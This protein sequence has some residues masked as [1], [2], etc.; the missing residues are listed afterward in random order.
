MTLAP[1]LRTWPD[2]TEVIIDDSTDQANGMATGFPYPSIRLNVA[3]PTPGD[4]ISETGLWRHELIMHEYTHILNFEPAH[5]I[6]RTVRSLFGSLGR[7]NMLLP[8]WYSEGLAVDLETRFSENAGRLRS[9]IFTAI[10]RSMIQE[11]RLEKED[12]ARINESSIPDWPNGHRPYLMGSLIWN[13]LNNDSVKNAGDLNDRYGSRV[14]FFI[15]EPIQDLK[16]LSWNELLNSVY[17]STEERAVYQLE[18]ICQGGCEEG[19]KIGEPGLFSKS[20]VL[21]ASKNWLAWIGKEHNRD[22]TLMVLPR[23]EN[24]FAGVVPIRLTDGKYTN[25]IAWAGLN[26]LYD[27]AATHMRYSERNDLFLFERESKRSVQ[28]TFGLRAREAD[29]LQFAADKYQKPRFLV[30]FITLEPGETVLNVAELTQNGE[31]WKLSTP[32][33]IFRPAKDERLAWPS[34]LS[35]NEV[36]FSLRRTNGHETLYKIDLKSLKTRSIDL[37]TPQGDSVQF[38]SRTLAPKPGIVFTS[39]RSG[40]SNIYFSALQSGEFARPVPLTNSTTR[41]F[42]AFVD[43]IDQ[44]L[45]YSRLDADGVHLRRLTAGTRL[46]NEAIVRGELTHIENLTPVSNSTVNSESSFS[47]AEPDSKLIAQN[48]IATDYSSFRYLVPQYWMP[49]V[50]WVPGGVFLSA[51]TSASDPLAKQVLAASVSIDTRIGSL[52]KFLSYTN[53]MS[54]AAITGLV[55]DNYQLLSTS[56]TRRTSTGDVSAQFYLPGASNFWSG[57]FGFNRQRLE[58]T[59]QGTSDAKLRGGFRAALSW[60]ELSQK[61]L[62]I[63]PEKSGAFRLAHAVYRPEF[64]DQVYDKTDLALTGYFSRDNHRTLL[65][66]LPPRNV[67][68]LSGRVNW[69][70]SLDRLLYGPSSLSLPIESLTLGSSSSSFVMRGYPSGAFV[71]RKVVQTSIEYRFPISNSY[72][73]FETKPAFIQRWHGDF[74]VDAVS[75]DGSIYDLANQV[76]RT[77]SL[78]TQFASVGF[79]TKLDTTL[80]YQMPVQF[81]FAIHY[82]FDKRINPAGAYPVI[83]LSM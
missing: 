39:S 66:W 46:Q 14:P 79:E 4:S 69:A 48:L 59:S 74:F 71:G 11:N 40:V 62:E 64:G 31:Q 68:V 22:S 63:S 72:Y 10:F 57:E 43:P 17:R 32:Q 26:L 45:I 15:E 8:R 49:Y 35:E 52:N 44:S 47:F 27:S 33:Q 78:G 25:R 37:S 21:D 50:Y 6:M 54:E 3:A 56:L 1:V 9:P 23:G 2:K 13:Y 83:S 41:A 55:D 29:V 7:S 12:I 36:I 5:G 18:R 67:F 73:G 28:L 38:A 60:Q 24:N 81:I 53:S 16:K 65:G 82:G 34:F 61:G 30:T 80:F 76:Y 58:L 75:I 70:P 20:V 51:S 42:G 19:V 77:S